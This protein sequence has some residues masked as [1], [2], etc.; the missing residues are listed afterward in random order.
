MEFQGGKIYKAYTK[1]EE[2]VCREIYLV[3]EHPDI[4]A[5]NEY[6]PLP[7]ININLLTTYGENG[8]PLKIERTDPPKSGK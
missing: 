8:V 6:E 5:C 3:V 4:P 2:L 1:Y 7:Q